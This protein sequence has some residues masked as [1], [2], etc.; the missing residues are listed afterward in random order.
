LGDGA[1]A[2]G[3]LGDGTVSPRTSAKQIVSS[4]VVAVDAGESYS[5]FLKTDGSLWGMGRNDVGQLGDGTTN[6]IHMPEQIV[7][8]GVIAI[9]AGR[10]HSLFLKSDHSLW[11]MGYNYDGELGDGA[12][13]ISGSYTNRPEQIVSSDV[14]AI[15]AGTAIACLSRPT[16]VFGPWVA[17]LTGSLE[18]APPTPRPTGRSKSSP[19]A[20]WRLPPENFTTSS[21]NP[22][23]AFGPWC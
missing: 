6:S 21:S 13:S 2:Y 14:V 9:A 19:A 18:M 20:S 17:T 5:L 15:A 4:N 7:S 8:S 10:N 16:A 12:G 11:G 22:T 23:A 3:Q 1:N